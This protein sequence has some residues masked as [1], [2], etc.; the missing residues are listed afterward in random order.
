MFIIPL[1]KGQVTK[2]S[3]EDYEEL[4]KFKWHASGNGKN[5]AYRPAR[6][7]LLEED[8]NKSLIY[9]YHQILKYNPAKDGLVVDHINRD[10]LDNR[11]ENLR[12]ITPFE[13]SRN[14]KPGRGLA[15]CNT[16][17]RWK[18]YVDIRTP[19]G[20]RRVN[21]GTYATFVEAVAA[22]ELKLQELG[23]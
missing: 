5:Q 13:N 22:R 17:S 11:R 23:L 21:V 1:T 15:Y 7:L 6:R 14:R 18:A 4:S 12:I 10:P 16:W 8:V 20:K 2:V 9:M 3:P 19:T